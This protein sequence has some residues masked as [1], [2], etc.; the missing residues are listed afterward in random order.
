[1][2]SQLVWD[3]PWTKEKMTFEGKLQASMLG[4]GQ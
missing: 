3:P 4:I 1:V 2:E